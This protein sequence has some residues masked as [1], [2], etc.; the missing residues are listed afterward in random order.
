MPLEK[1]IPISLFLF[2]A[3]S[4]EI[5][6]QETV[7]LRGSIQSK[8][9]Q[10]AGGVN[11]INLATGAGTS[12]LDDGQFQI[13]AKPGDSIY[14]SSVQFENKILGVSRETLAAPIVI[15]LEEK[16]NEMEEIEVSNLK[17]SGYL[18]NDAAKIPIRN[19]DNFGLPMPGKKR[20]Q[21]ER[22][23][24]AATTGAGGRRLSVLGVLF[25]SIP[26][27]PILNGING[28][29][30]YLKELNEQDKLEIRVQEGINRLG[31]SYFTD[32]LKIRKE[33]IINFVFF[34]ADQPD[35]NIIL[36]SGDNLELIAFFE[37]QITDFQNIGQDE[38]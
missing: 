15:F 9:E 21:T 4:S 13:T 25:G 6:A 2:I 7:L 29:T 30:K 37:N 1:C 27:D 38:E 36:K 22:R 5:R 19:V 35:Y 10:P 31:E 33:E 8:N 17:L 34:C 28:R 14:F 20:T 11:I 3:Y 26:L 24:F 23:L 32:F 18:G 12:S 16:L